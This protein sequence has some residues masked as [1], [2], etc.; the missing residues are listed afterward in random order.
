MVIYKA[1]EMSVPILRTADVLLM[2][3]EAKIRKGGAGAGDA[4][5]NMQLEVRDRTWPSFQCWYAR[6]DS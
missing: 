4:E 5:I 6:V 1:Y 3:A 2:V